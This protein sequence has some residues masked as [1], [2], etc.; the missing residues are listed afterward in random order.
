MRGNGVK[1]T[2]L[3][4]KN[5]AFMVSEWIFSGDILIEGMVNTGKAHSTI[6]VLC[7]LIKAYRH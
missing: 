2:W 7:A 3:R 4:G 5:H 1:K 6:S